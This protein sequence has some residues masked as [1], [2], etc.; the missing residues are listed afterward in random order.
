VVWLAAPDRNSHR[1]QCCAGQLAS[2]NESPVPACGPTSGAPATHTVQ[3][4][5]QSVVHGA[6]YHPSIHRDRARA[7]SACLPVPLVVGSEIPRQLLTAKRCG[8]LRLARDT[9]AEWQSSK[10]AVLAASLGFST[11][12][13]FCERA[14]KTMCARAQ[15]ATATSSHVNGCTCSPACRLSTSAFWRPQYP[16]LPQCTCRSPLATRN[17]R[18]GD[19]GR[20]HHRSRQRKQ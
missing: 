10:C 17:G 15:R 12:I 6:C 7:K 2:E 1:N 4:W 16:L 5:L 13:E 3:S 8:S 14:L 11:L 18:V 20:Q 19:R 9:T